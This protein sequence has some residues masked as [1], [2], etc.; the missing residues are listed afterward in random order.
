MLAN[1]VIDFD[2]PVHRW[3]YLPLSDHFLLGVD[4]NTAIATVWAAGLQIV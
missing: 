4:V 3:T 2:Y 1:I